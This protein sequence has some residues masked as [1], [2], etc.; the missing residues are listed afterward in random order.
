MVA[1]AVADMTEMAEVAE[2]AGEAEAGLVGL[3]HVRP[4]VAVF[5]IA[6]A[7]NNDEDGS[8][9]W[10][11]QREL[12]EYSAETVDVV[13]I[14]VRVEMSRNYS[15]QIINYFDVD[16]IREIDQQTCQERSDFD[17]LVIDK[18]IKKLVP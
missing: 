12:L 5:R 7:V 11:P 18:K 16:L 14:K 2:N 9:L 3:H 10:K 15:L 6:D 8:V 13:D 17:D 1:A 4:P